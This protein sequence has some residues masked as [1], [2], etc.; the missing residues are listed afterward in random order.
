MTD[1]LEKIA[2]ATDRSWNAGEPGNFTMKVL[3]AVILA[4]YGAVPSTAQT[5]REPE[6]FFKE[7]IHLKDDQIAS[8]EHGKP[9]VQ[10]LPGH[11]PSEIAVFGAIY[12]KTSPEDYLNAMQNV[13][14][15]R[16]SH[17]YLAMRQISA[18]P[19]LSDFEGFVFE[20]ED[21]KDLRNCKP[22]RCQVQLP[23]ESIEEFQNAVDWSAADAAAQVNS[24]AQKRAFEELIKYQKEGN[25]ALGA[26]YD[27]EQPVYVIKQFE[28]LVNQLF[29]GSHYLPDL[30]Q[31]LVEYPRVRLPN[32]EDVFYWERVNFGLKPTLRLNHAVIYRGPEPSQQVN[33][34]A[35]KQLY[36]SHYF[37]TALDVSLCARDTHREQNGSYLITIKASRQAGL[38]GPKGSLI[39]KVAVSRTCSSLE[40]SLTHIKRIL[41]TGQG[42]PSAGID[43][44]Q[45]VRA[46]YMRTDR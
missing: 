45:L 31:Y 17:N 14:N 32:A 34:I 5:S 46:G 16:N 37:Q 13:N 30:K 3:G 10:V 20:D 43:A 44:L 27:K 21:I 28:T 7:Y 6:T 36:A 9:I 15:L 39:R 33:A 42:N 12:I 1:I 38:T 19:K 23:V 22:G 40:T 25:N 8:I 11:V 18:P 41:E 24:L 2:R 26:Y 35:V 4:M 29:S